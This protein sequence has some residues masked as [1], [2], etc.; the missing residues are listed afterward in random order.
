[1]LRLFV[2]GKLNPAL[3]S[4]FGTGSVLL[5]SADGEAYNLYDLDMFGDDIYTF[6]AYIFKTYGNDRFI[7]RSVGVDVFVER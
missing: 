4:N 5:C 6:V 3:P 1:M 7:L 2:D